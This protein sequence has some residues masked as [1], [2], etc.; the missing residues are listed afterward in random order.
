MKKRIFQGP[1]II[2]IIVFW[3][4]YTSTSIMVLNYNLQ[5]IN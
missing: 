4:K 5:A 3:H 2:N 1:F